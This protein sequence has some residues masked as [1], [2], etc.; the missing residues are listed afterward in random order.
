MPRGSVREALD[1]I[2]GAFKAVGVP[3]P[4]ASIL[5]NLTPPSIPKDGTWLDLPLA[6]IML[7][8]AGLLPDLPDHLE[9]DY[10]IVGEL[11]IHGE[12]RRVPGV[13]SL[14]LMSKPGQKLIIPAGNEKE[15]ALILAITGTRGMWNLSRWIS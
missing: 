6:I 8:T 4:Q 2:C 13:L 14:A 12:V 9:G 3:D 5:I 10:V 15:A 7:Q 1:R 11:G